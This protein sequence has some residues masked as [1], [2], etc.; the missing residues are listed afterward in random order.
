MSESCAAIIGWL[1]TSGSLH[2]IRWRAAI[3]L[4]VAALPPFDA[5][6]S[7]WPR[8]RGPNGSGVAES[9]GLPDRAGPE[10]NVIWKTPLPPGHSS[11]VLSGKHI[12]ITAT[13][14]DKLW[15]LCLSRA[16]GEVLWR[17]ECVRP[18]SEKLD[19][20]NNAASPS[21][22]ADGGNVYIFFPDFGLVSYDA[23]G[24]L[25]WRTPLGPFHNVYGMGASPILAGDLVVL[26]CDQS[27]GSFAAGFDARTGKERWRTPRPE[28][29][30]GHS[31]PIVYTPPA[32][33]PQVLAPGSFRLDAYD[34]AT[35]KIS[36]YTH[37][38]ASEMKSVPVL[39]AGTLFI[40][41][42]NT[43]ENDPGRQVTIPA[44]EEVLP[45]HDADHDGKISLAE[46]PDERTRRYFPFIDLDQDGAMDAREWHLYQSSMAAENGLLALKPGGAGDV[47]TSA[48]RW[49][50]QRS[51]PQ[52]P[53]VLVY[54][55]V[56]YMINDSGVLTT[57]DAATGALHK[58]AR[59]RGVSDNYY[60]SPV[61]GDG[62]IFIL[63]HTGVLAILKAGPDQEVLSVSNLDEEC[64][65]TPAIADGRI[66]LRTRGTL[67]CFGKSRE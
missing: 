31:T 1:K 9:A 26:V 61:A 57:L 36:W 62:K 23:A 59:L 14:Q 45:K 55:G 63:S 52:L 11:P 37:G 30:S 4:A 20:R 35:G 56:V 47:T 6:A 44:W 43:P 67:Y 13:D 41:G 58:Q 29:L 27:S 60:A 38:L 25:R 39:D 18:R 54:R 17:R 22:A 50:F 3:W 49:K 33:G 32:G 8:F 51:I 24:N 5:G 48:L 10:I 46:V 65:A 34:A 42:Y 53:S 40:N 2:I 7:D 16:T 28:A 12:F 15:T 66:Y 21:P 64:F 19:K